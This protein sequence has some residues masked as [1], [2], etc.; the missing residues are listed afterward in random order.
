[1]GVLKECQV[2]VADAHTIDIEAEEPQGASAGRHGCAGAPLLGCPVQEYHGVQ[3]N[4]RG[5][6]NAASTGF[7]G[8][9]E[10]PWMLCKAPDPEMPGSNHFWESSLEDSCYK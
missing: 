7:A 9:R 4:A 6:D 2:F 5:P 10:A 1:M 3:Y 8:L